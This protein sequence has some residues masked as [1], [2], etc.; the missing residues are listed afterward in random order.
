MA[1][2]GLTRLHE[3]GKGAAIAAITPLRFS[4]RSAHWRSALLR[5]AVD[6]TGQPISSY[7]YP[8]IDFLETFDFKASKVLEFGGAWRRRSPFDV[9]VIDGQ[10][11]L[12]CA[13]VALQIL[14]ADG[15]VLLDNSEGY[16]APSDAY[17]IIDLFESAGFSRVDFHGYTPTTWRKQ[18]TSLFFAS[19]ARLRG[20]SPPHRYD[21]DLL[22]SPRT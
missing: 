1:R 21:G 9:V 16:W 18:C 6:P 19:P 5:R 7:F 12:T 10:K 15:L 20:L 8:A 22:R 3:L 14:A 13:R 2:P 17:P 11:R 4:L